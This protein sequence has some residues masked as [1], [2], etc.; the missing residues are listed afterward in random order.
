M[1]KRTCANQA[2]WATAETGA[3]LLS[4][5]AAPAG[6]LGA[7]LEGVLLGLMRNSWHPDPHTGRDAAPGRP[8]GWDGP[9][10]CG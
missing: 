10:H 2:D 6:A 5:S 3:G 1:H 8:I 4:G 7:L 9:G